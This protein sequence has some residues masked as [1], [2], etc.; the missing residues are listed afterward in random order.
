MSKAEQCRKQRG[1]CQI[2]NRPNLQSQFIDHGKE[3]SGW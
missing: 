2:T 1:K 3:Q